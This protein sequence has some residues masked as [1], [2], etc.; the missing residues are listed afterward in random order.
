MNP[1]NFIVY[2]TGLFWLTLTDA[3]IG[4][5]WHI[6]DLHYDPFHNSLELH[7]GCRHRGGS[8][9]N[10]RNERHRDHTCDSSWALIQSA[11]ALM[12]ARHPDTLEFVL[13][14]G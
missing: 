1:A 12:A 14:T 13:W 9:H 2:I 8:E 3:K 11:A 6:T 5:F 4:Y 10:H 7:R